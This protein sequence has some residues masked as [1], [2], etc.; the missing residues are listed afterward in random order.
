MR[1]EVKE[2][3]EFYLENAEDL[4]PEVGYVALPDDIYKAAG[5]RFSSMK[6]GSVMSGKEGS[7]KELYMAK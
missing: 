5:K 7:L 6:T 2:F 4:V 1:P 3:V